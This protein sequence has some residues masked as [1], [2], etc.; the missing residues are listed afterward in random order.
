MQNFLVLASAGWAVA[1]TAPDQRV[2][3]LLYGLIRSDA[4]LGLTAP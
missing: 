4:M 3:V 1:A 2:G